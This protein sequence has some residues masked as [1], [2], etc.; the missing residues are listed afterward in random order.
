MSPAR[1][2][3]DFVRLPEIPLETIL[4]HMSDPRVSVHLPLGTGR[5]TLESCAAFVA[6][7]EACWVRDGL[8]HWAILCDGGYAGWG[9]FQKEGDEW[10]FGLVLTAGAFGLGARITRQALGI[11]RVDPRIP[12]VTFLLPP[13]RKHLGGLDRLGATPLGAVDYAGERFLKFRLDT[14]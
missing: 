11:A 6:A 8:G 12:F 9:G 10:D 14:A 5:W 4:A 1:P 13:S 3:I 7:K 2:K